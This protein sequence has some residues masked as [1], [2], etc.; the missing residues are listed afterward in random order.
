MNEHRFDSKKVSDKIN[1]FENLSKNNK[2]KEELKE[3]KNKND[4]IIFEE[5]LEPLIPKNREKYFENKE[6]IELDVEANVD[7]E[8]NEGLETKIKRKIKF[9]G[10]KKKKELS[11]DYNKIED[12]LDELDKI[13]EDLYI[14][15]NNRKKMFD[16]FQCKMIFKN[17][18]N[19]NEHMM[20]HSNEN[21]NTV[22][23]CKKCGLIFENDTSYY[24]HNDNCMESSF[25]EETIPM[26]PDG[27]YKCPS[28][29]NKYS[30]NFLLGEHF[31]LRHN[32]YNILCSLDEI[33]HCGF[34]GFEILL[35][36]GMIHKVNIK[37]YLNKQCDICFFDFCDNNIENINNGNRSPIKMVCCKRLICHDC[38]MNHIILT[39]TLIC[40]YCRRDHTRIDLDYIK[41]IEITETTDRE[42]WLPWWENH[43]EIFN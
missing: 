42:K 27:K 12:Q 24:N 14:D 23:V 20:K 22:C 4:L 40:P 43:I 3:K 16:C 36:I 1:Y 18:E 35:E 7:I 25:D 5:D 11:K 8:A 19:Y 10:K 37:K 32:D 38:I 15:R 31:I 29:N 30:N 28:C 2:E 21:E 13:V 39:D 41:L 6:M 33:N 17:E 34:P 26:D 9:K